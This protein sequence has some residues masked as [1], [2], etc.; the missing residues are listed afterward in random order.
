[1]KVLLAVD[2]TGFA[3]ASEP[4]NILRAPSSRLPAG[5]APML[6]ALLGCAFWALE[7]SGTGL[8]A[9]VAAAA[10]L[11]LAGA[12]SYWDRSGMRVVQVPVG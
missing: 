7:A 5:I 3:Q 11:L 9:A 12:L 6:V 1:M 2:T 8:N 4:N 10:L